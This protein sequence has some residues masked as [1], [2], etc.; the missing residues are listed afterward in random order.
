MTSMLSFLLLLQLGSFV[1]VNGYTL[2][3]P[4]AVS[5]NQ[6]NDDVSQDDVMGYLDYL[7]ELREANQPLEGG[8][9][10]RGFYDGQTLKDLM[11]KRRDYAKRRLC[12]LPTMSCNL[13][14]NYCC[15]NTTCRCNLWGQNCRCL[16]MGFFQ[17]W[18][19]R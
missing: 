1:V 16:R 12:I 8:V 15:E 9:Q 5:L 4:D 10:K 11:A 6:M 3:D 13:R 7:Q 14:P 19:K 17:R 18:G 2:D